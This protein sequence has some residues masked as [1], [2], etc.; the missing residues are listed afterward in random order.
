MCRRQKCSALDCPSPQQKPETCQPQRQATSRRPWKANR[1][2]APKSRSWKA[3]GQS[4]RFSAVNSEHSCRSQNECTQQLL[5]SET[6][7][8]VFDAFLK[9]SLRN[10]NASGLTFAYNC[11]CY[12]HVKTMSS[13]STVS[14]GTK[15]I[16]VLAKP[17]GALKFPSRCLC[18]QYL[19]IVITSKSSLWCNG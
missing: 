17:A 14:L 9:L 4:F 11:Y 18:K 19:K 6:D 16:T 15:L 10:W 2:G 3:R 5:T 8:C 1:R 12:I 7:I 13:F